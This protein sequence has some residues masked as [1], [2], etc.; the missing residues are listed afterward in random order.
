MKTREFIIT[1]IFIVISLGLYIIFPAKDIFQQLMGTIVFLVLLPF[2]FIKYILKNPDSVIGFKV[3]EHKKGLL[4]SGA[5]LIACFLI[6]AVQSY[7]YNFLNKYAV[8]SFIVG[9]FFKFTAYELFLI[10]PIVVIFDF[11]FRGFIMGIFS[12][13]IGYWSILFQSIVFF[14]FL[15]F[16]GSNLIQFAPYL[17]FSIFGGWIAFKSRSLIYSTAAQFILIFVLNVI[18]IKKLG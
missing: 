7:F 18:I 6:F 17:I 9:N 8:P 1:M 3:G 12:K 10:L 16:S 5:S 13:K 15:L 4:Y 11:Y 2:I 14:L